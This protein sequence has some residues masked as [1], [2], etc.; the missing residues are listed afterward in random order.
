MDLED[1]KLCF[2]LI[3]VLWSLIH[4]RGC[5]SLLLQKPCKEG[6][7]GKMCARVQLVRSRTSAYIS[8]Y[9]F[10]CQLNVDGCFFLSFSSS[11]QINAWIMRKKIK[12]TCSKIAEK[13]T[14]YLC[15]CVCALYTLQ[16]FFLFD[17]QKK[18]FKFVANVW[19]AA[20]HWNWNDKKR[21]YAW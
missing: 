2:V 1:I 17:E 20:E 10:N 5:F 7:W 19:S 9:D 18:L 13:K 15:V 12:C 4:F 11:I 21:Q 3:Y 14:I 8:L 16:I 6:E